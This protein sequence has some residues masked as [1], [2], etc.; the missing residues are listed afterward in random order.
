MV[1]YC[2]IVNITFPVLNTMTPETVEDILRLNIQ[3]GE[4]VNFKSTENCYS[5]YREM[6]NYDDEINSV[7]YS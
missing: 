4:P 3:Y 7:L 1:I 5:N 2:S 6:F